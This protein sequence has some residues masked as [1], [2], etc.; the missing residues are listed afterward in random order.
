MTA[1]HSVA[2]GGAMLH[3]EVLGDG[4]P[5]IFLH[6]AVCDTR[7]WSHQMAGIAPH[8]KAIAYDRRGFG[9]TRYEPEEY[10]SVADLM[11]LLDALGDDKP[12]VLVGCSQG[13][14]T[15]LNAALEHPS[16]V[17]GL[18]L[19]APNVPGAPEPDHAPDIAELFARQQQATDDGNIERLSAIKARLWL[20]GPLAQEGRVSGEVRDLL[21]EMSSIALGSPPEGEDLDLSRISPAYDRLA[22]IAVP[23]LMIWGELEFPYIAERCRMTADRIPDCA[24][25]ALPGTAHLPSLDQPDRVTSALVEFLGRWSS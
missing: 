25:L 18:V 10:S 22:D 9:K 16:R 23:T 4:I 15:A 12:A 13:G 11:A 20:D 1:H 6:A 21:L 7:M 24:C 19:I 8:C 5:V 3:A 17:C 2:T 14:R